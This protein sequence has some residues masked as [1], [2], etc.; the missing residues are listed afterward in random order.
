MS[1]WTAQ[2]YAWARHR[3]L[4]SMWCRVVHVAGTDNACFVT[5]C[6]GRFNAK[7]A[8][9]FEWSDEPRGARC[10]ECVRCGGIDNRLRD[11]L[12]GGAA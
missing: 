2:V 3:S 6:N 4:S 9:Q 12:I 7:D 10:E 8:E 11:A 5:A 1:D